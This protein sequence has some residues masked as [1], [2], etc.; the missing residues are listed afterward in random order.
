ME[1]T[2][3]RKYESLGFIEVVVAMGVA[4]IALTV[5][6]GM[7]ISSM[8]EAIRYERQD[9]LVRLA[10][11]GA[12]VVRRHVEKSQTPGLPEEGT[13][14][15]LNALQCYR[16]DFTNEVV[17]TT[18]VSA[19]AFESTSNN[20]FHREIVYDQGITNITDRAYIGYCVEAHDGVVIEGSIRTGYVTAHKDVPEYSY[21]IVVIVD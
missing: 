1:K 2:K 10:M 6:I 20:N 11:D 16:I 14:P 18:S 17:T 4:A 13:F 5:F 21:P 15:T 8:T 19:N 9:A 3:N 12:L 7:A